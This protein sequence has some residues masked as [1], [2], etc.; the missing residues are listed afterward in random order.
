MTDIPT[1]N[2][3][4]PKHWRLA[5][6]DWGELDTIWKR[7]LP[8]VLWNVGEQ[9]LLFHWLD[10]AVD[11]GSESIELTVVDRPVDVRQHIA[12]AS[13]WPIE[14]K[15][16]SVNSI[17]PDNV[18][19][20]VDR[21]PGTPTLSKSPA[22]GWSLLRHWF[23]IEQDWLI[24]FAEDTKQYGKYA[25]IGRSCKI[26]PDVKLN[27][28][29]WI[30]NFVSIGPG[31]VIGP[32]A[33]VE[34]GSILPGGNR[35]ERGHVGAYTYLGPET[36][37]SDAAIHKNEL[38]NFKHQAHIKNLESFVAGGLDKN[39]QDHAPSPAFKERW[40]ALKLYLKWTS[41][42]SGS[43]MTFTDLSGQERPALSD[44]SVEARR[45]WLKEVVKGK[46]LLFGVTPRTAEKLKGVP[47]D[48]QAIL[49]EAPTGAFSYAD[50][51]G[52]H[53]IGSDEE[54]LHSVYQAGVN[55]ERCHELFNNW[56][57]ELT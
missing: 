8:F 34:D 36:S 18:D 11:Q 35:V 12:D 46:L 3:N 54:T 7:K 47:E 4:G 51:M 10:A 49:R 28:P 27:P 6:P 31:S 57:K 50:V 39:K 16:R 9:A 44:S 38:V 15:V 2:R 32:G 52:A 40:A 21:L 55:A 25:A 14:I 17:D 56:L 23:E 20:I 1:Q 13:L 45:P 26:A 5:L 37:L 29:F 33:V 19:D 41:Q 53:D 48:W 43:E 22:D 42:G 30:G 24:Q